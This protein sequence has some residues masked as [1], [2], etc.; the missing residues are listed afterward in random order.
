[1][2]FTAAVIKEQGAVFAV[3]VVKKSVLSSSK[4]EEVRADYARFL[5]HPTV[6]MAQDSKGVPAYWGDKKIVRFLCSIDMS[7]IP[8]Q[9]FTT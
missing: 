9:K 5:G 4:R 8:W 3:V 7:R 6:L 2:Q 1:M